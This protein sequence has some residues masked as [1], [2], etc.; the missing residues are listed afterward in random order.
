MGP[1]RRHGLHNVPATWVTLLGR[2]DFERFEQPSLQIEI[3]QIIIHKADQPDVV[4]HFLDADGLPG[5]H[6]AEIDF[7]L[8]ETNAAAMRNYN[9]SVVEWVVDVRQSLVRTRR[10]LIDPLE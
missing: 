2:T 7:F 8:A 10:G 3:F 5:K 9:R 4:L 6:R 1:A